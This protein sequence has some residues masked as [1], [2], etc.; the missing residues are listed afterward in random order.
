MGIILE[1]SL[2]EISMDLPISY[3]FAKTED[4]FQKWILSA[5]NAMMLDIL[6]A[7]TRKN[8]LDR[9]RLKGL[10]KQRALESIKE[11]QRI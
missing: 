11:D 6:A 5:V 4:D 2:K 9:S 10:I 7:T 3:T 1:N 8:Y